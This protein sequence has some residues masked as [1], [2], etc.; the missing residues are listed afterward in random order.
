M[1]FKFGEKEFY[2]QVNGLSMGSP[3]APVLAEMYLNEF[4]KLYIADQKV[5]KYYFYYRFVDD[6][7][8]IVPES[9]DLNELFNTIN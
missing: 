6:I 2:K 9:T 5:I 3:L 8:M 1:S 4:E 7:F